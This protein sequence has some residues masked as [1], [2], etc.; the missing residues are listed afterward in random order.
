MRVC[1]YHCVCYKYMKVISNIYIY[2]YIYTY[3][4]RR[5][6]TYELVMRTSS[7]LQPICGNGSQCTEKI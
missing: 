1:F 6:Y 4:I 3:E 7:S 2:I 5:M